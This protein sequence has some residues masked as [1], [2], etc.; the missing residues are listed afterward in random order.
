MQRRQVSDPWPAPRAPG[1]LDAVV[2]LP[3]SKSVTNRALVLA[4]LAPG[5][6]V[7]RRPLR[8]R[9]TELM[10]AA[11]RVLGVPV[12]DTTDGDWVVD[13]AAR[14]LAPTGTA[15][16]VGNAGTVARFL[17][18]VACLAA[19]EVVFDGD[20]RVRERPLGPLL[21]ALRSLGA[22][23]DRVDALPVRVRGSGGLRGGDVVLDAS[24][25]SQLVSGL[26]LAA[27]RFDEGLR[28]RHEGP[29]LPSAPHLA[30]TVEALRAAGAQ[31]D[32]SEPGTWQ[33]LPGGL[34]ARDAAVE[35]DLS[36]A[37]AYLAAPLVA[38][39]SVTISDWPADTTQPGAALPGLLAQMGAMVSRYAGDLTVTGG[40]RLRGL[41][42]DLRDCGELTPVLTALAALADS[43]SRF[44]GVAHLRVQETD[45][46]A[47]L[48]TEL[49][50]IGGDVRELPDG[51]RVQPRPLGPGVLDSYDDHRI[52][53]AWAVLGLGTDGIAVADV[54]TTRKTV[55]D[56]VGSWE[57]LLGSPA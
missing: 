15:V 40:D 49:N 43:P 38:G 24:Q 25:S 56:F 9:D 44:T 20:P 12:S 32:D 28:V 42:A 46:L 48:A 16:D 10:A 27:P 57:Q 47:A 30:M 45:R 13:G 5:R 7:V 51:L 4:A 14:P 54:A 34:T 33:V 21:R 41:E 36:T 8:S 23:L 55:P 39:G 1:P 19:G 18:P 52:A 26:L 6:S 53:M 11:L 50:G 29:P 3:G 35:P 22:D 2:V 17:P 31:V 37:A